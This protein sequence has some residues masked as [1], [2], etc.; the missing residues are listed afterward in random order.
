MQGCIL[1]DVAHF[2]LAA[3]IQHADLPT[4]LHALVLENHL[5][6]KTSSA[7]NVHTRGCQNSLVADFH[8]DKD[9]GAPQA[10]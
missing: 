6:D 2:F 9:E 3:I 7:A 5:L 1:P 4:A 10:H 8:E